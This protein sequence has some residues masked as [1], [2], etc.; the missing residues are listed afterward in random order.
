MCLT[1]QNNVDVIHHE[2][3]EVE[4]GQNVTLPCII[5][6]TDGLHMVNIEWSRNKANKIK[7]AL[8]SPGLG[9]KEFVDNVRIETENNH[10]ASYLHLYGVTEQNSDVYICDLTVF[11]MGSFRSETQLRIKGKAN[12]TAILPYTLQSSWD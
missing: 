3:L 10:M 1:G 11:P 8:C 9:K 2:K 5:N 6:M 4:V 7:L 12:T